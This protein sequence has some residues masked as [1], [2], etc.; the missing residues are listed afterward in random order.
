MSTQ[1]IKRGVRHP[2]WQRRKEARPDEIV[3]AALDLFVEKGF[4]A[5]RLE[6]VAH[7]AG[8]SKG[9]MYLYFDSKESLF[10]AAVRRALVPTLEEGE[11][12]LASH[13][14]PSGELLAT[15]IRRWWE[16][17]GVSKGSGILKL[18]IAESANFPDITRIYHQE[19]VQRGRQ[20]VAA[21]LQRGIDR[22]EFRPVDVPRTV[23]LAMAPL[24]YAVIW[25]HSLIRCDSGETDWTTFIENHIE[26]FLRGLAA[27]RKGA[28]S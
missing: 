23:R 8:V 20:L 12:L 2:R 11:A 10:Q 27:E 16:R 18:M 22:G 3:E 21:A 9:T 14:G 4:A 7:R 19:I 28:A 15:L 24:L 6:D 25:K 13:Q 26:L 5:T 17:T 1:V